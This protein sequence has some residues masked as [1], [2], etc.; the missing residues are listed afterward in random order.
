MKTDFRI[1]DGVIRA[2][3]AFSQSLRLFPVLPRRLG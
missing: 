1:G 3:S 2:S